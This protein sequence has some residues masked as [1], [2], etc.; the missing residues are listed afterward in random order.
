MIRINNIKDVIKS[1]D[2]VVYEFESVSLFPEVSFL[3]L[4]VFLLL[5]LEFDLLLFEFDFLME[6]QTEHLEEFGFQVYV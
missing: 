5:L 3:L 1:E 2:C 6:L 4:L